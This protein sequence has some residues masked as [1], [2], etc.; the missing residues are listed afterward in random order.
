MVR[1]KSNIDQWWKRPGWIVTA[2]L[3]LVAILSNISTLANLGN[4]AFAS[5]DAVLL[6]PREPDMVVLGEGRQLAIELNNR[7]HGDCGVTLNVPIVIPE[8]GLEIRENTRLGQKLTEGASIMITYNLYAR[9]T[10]TYRITFSGTQ[11]A[12]TLLGSRSV[13]TLPCT[14]EVWPAVDANPTVEY[15]WLTPNGGAVYMVTAR[16]GHPPGPLIQYQAVLKEAN[17]SFTGVS[18]ATVI[19]N[20]HEGGVAV[21]IWQAEAKSSP[22]P[23]QF[24]V[25]VNGGTN[26]NENYWRKLRDV[27]RVDAQSVERQ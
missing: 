17:L 19:H 23:Q 7:T 26:S 16:H 22:V 20:S 6:L 1:R 3:G 25:I 5:P 11:H 12:G 2:F 27:L 4:S 14:I 24:E 10:G 18:H 8:K 13:P 21:L 15:K 9:K